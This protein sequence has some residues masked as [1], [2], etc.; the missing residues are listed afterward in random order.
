MWKKDESTKVFAR[1]LPMADK[2]E[3]ITDWLICFGQSQQGYSDPHHYICP[4]LIPTDLDA[5][6]SHL[7][8]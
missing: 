4:A 5:D 1:I 3:Q 7:L 2:T 6:I 8:R